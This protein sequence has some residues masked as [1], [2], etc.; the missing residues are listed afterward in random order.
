MPTPTPTETPRPTQTPTKTQTQ[1]P[2]H[3]QTPTNTNTPTH[4]Q[5]QTVTPSQPEIAQC[6]SSFEIVAAYYAEPEY[7]QTTA[8]T[9]T[10]G[11]CTTSDCAPCW[12][13]HGCDDARF[14]VKANTI[15]LYDEANPSKNTV[16]LNNDGTTANNP[17]K[18]DKNYPTV[19][20]FSPGYIGGS[21][22]DKLTIGATQASA[23]AASSQDGYV[24]FGLVCALTDVTCHTG[25]T[26][27]RLYCNGVLLYSGCPDGNFVTINPCTGKVKP[28]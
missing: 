5:T 10:Y 18:D 25:V 26:W 28:K 15:V 17:H 9:Y 7:V 1:T 6:L 2:S 8:T 21:R 24:T 23:I 19:A 4:T 12:Q 13:S 14:Y 11:T 20:P 16:S 27:I 22:Y 3:T